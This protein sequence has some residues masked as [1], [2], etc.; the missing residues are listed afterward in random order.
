MTLPLS[1]GDIGLDNLSLANSTN[2][3]ES[4]FSKSSDKDDKNISW[5]KSLKRNLSSKRR[6]KQAKSG[7]NISVEP[8]M[9]VTPGR[10]IKSEW[11]ICDEVEEEREEGFRRDLEAEYD[12]LGVVSGLDLAHRKYC[13]VKTRGKIE[14]H[15]SYFHLV[16]SD[17]SNL[18]MT[19]DPRRMAKLANID[20][21]LLHGI[22][23]FNLDPSKGLDILEE[24][25]FVKIEEESLASFLLN[26]ER[27][28]KKQ[29]GKFIKIILLIC[30]ICI[31]FRF[32]SRIAR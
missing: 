27:L 20:K 1:S 31:D 19:L 30:S 18:F 28:S 4:Q 24:R 13:K 7:G 2:R 8:G 15:T 14:Y 9:L 5:F 32:I 26:Q 6:G 21:H 25:G 22:K 3:N 10:R 12:N 29:I 17:S 23:Q 11:D 16:I